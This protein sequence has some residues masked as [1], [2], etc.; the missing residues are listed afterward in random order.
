MQWRLEVI[1]S[2]VQYNECSYG[3]E[4][5]LI[6]PCAVTYLYALPCDLHTSLLLVTCHFIRSSQDVIKPVI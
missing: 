4:G 5:Y 6:G 1:L 3:A 2:T